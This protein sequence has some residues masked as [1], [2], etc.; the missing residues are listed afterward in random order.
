MDHILLVD[1]EVT[2]L[3]SKVIEALKGKLGA[4]LRS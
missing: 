4:E 3:M 1:D 2:E